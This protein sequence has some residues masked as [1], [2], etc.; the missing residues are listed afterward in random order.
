MCVAIYKPKNVKTPSIE[1][2]KKCWETNPHGAGFAML[3][4]KGK[5][6]IE[7]KKGFMTWKAFKEAYHKNNLA[8]FEGELFLHFRI[9]THGGTSPENTHPFC[10]SSSIKTLRHTMLKTNYALVHNGILPIEPSKK[11]ISDTM[12][13][14][15]RLANGGYYKDI[16]TLF[17]LV[18]GML[19]E[20]KIA[21]MTADKVHL[22]G[23]WKDHEG[24]KYSNMYWNQPPAIGYSYLGKSSYNLYGERYSD[25][26]GTTDYNDDGEFTDE[27][28][29]ASV[30]D[31]ICPYCGNVVCK[32]FDIFFC[33]DCGDLYCDDT[34]Y[35]EETE[36]DKLF[37]S[38][39]EAKRPYW[40][41]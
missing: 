13:L 26:Y 24:S 5:L 27:F 9:T 3:T 21:I 41:K 7:I 38:N 15:K 25:V 34:E 29:K 30:L 10:I 8:S 32:D 4:N 1:T 33:K 35:G 20:N 6:P 2:L 36:K 11:T 16:A 17:N 31:G 18:D 19:G 39:Y 40:R 14:C 23:N 22:F 37:K 12:E 28:I